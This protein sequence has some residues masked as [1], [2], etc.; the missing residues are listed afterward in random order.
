VAVHPLRA[1]RIGT[2]AAAGGD[3]RLGR[4]DEIVD[5]RPWVSFDGRREC[6]RV[7]MAEPVLDNGLGQAVLL[8]LVQGDPQQPVIVG[9]LRDTLPHPAPPALDRSLEVDGRRIALQGHEEVVLRCGEASITLRADG[10]VL[11]KGT[12]ITSRAAQAHKIRG[13]TVHIN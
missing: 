7:A 10:Q 12:H 3:V 9:L 1:R 6:A 11:I 2:V 4:I 5:G 8:L 13:A